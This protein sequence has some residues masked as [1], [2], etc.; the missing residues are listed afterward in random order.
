M[1]LRSRRS[2]PLWKNAAVPA[3]TNAQAATSRRS[4]KRLIADQAVLRFARGAALALR[5]APG[6][7]LLTALVRYRMNDYSVPTAYGFRDVLAIPKPAKTS[8]LPE[9]YVGPGYE[10]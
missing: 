7:N 1:L 10:T 6:Q 9:R 4:V 3:R 2:T 5:Q 8:A